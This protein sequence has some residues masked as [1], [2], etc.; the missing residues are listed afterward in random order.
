MALRVEWSVEARDD[1]RKIAEFIGRD[2]RAYA[3][4][5]VRRVLRG[6]RKL[7]RFPQMGRVVPELGDEAFRELLV[8]GFRVIYRVEGDLVTITAVAHGRQS[9]DLAGE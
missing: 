7:E 9:L 1:L 4:A 5:V 6:T 2:S 3:A 8:Y